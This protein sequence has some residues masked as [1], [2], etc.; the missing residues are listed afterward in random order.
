MWT[1]WNSIYIKLYLNLRCGNRVVL[2]NIVSSLC[3]HKSKG[4]YVHISGLNQVLQCQ[5]LAVV[6]VGV[7]AEQVVLQVDRVV[8]LGAVSIVDP[9]FKHD[10]LVQLQ[11]QEAVGDLVVGDEGRQQA[12]P[13]DVGA[14]GIGDSI[15]HLLSGH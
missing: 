10:H 5:E 9:D 6:K 4:G 14:W 7:V 2:E 8:A 13:A 15:S 12:T 3:E 11:T 1:P